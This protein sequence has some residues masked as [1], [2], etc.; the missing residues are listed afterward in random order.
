M[1]GF[2]IWSLN[3]LIFPA[4]GISCLKQKDAVG[5]FTL[6]EAP[7]VTDVRKYNK[8]VAKLWFVSGI[9]FEALG[10]PLLFLEQNS[11]L[12]VPVILGTFALIIGLIVVYMR[13]ENK[14]RIK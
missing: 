11:P 3:A 2:I 1:F 10:V 5:F 4:L 13:I 9:I 14:Y 12:F 6:R 8:A 7:K